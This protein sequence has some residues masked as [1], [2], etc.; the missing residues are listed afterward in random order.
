MLKTR[1]DIFYN[2]NIANL[3]IL[4]D[5]F[6]NLK[7]RKKFYNRFIRNLKFYISKIDKIWDLTKR[8][9]LYMV[10]HI[11]DNKKSTE[12]TKEHIY[13]LKD[14]FDYIQNEKNFTDYSLYKLDKKIY[15]DPNC[16]FI[17]KNRYEE[18]QQSLYI[19]RQDLKCLKCE[20]KGAIQ[21]YG[22]WSNRTDNM[23]H[24]I[25]FGGTIPY[26]CTNCGN[27]G[28]DYYPLEGYE[29]TFEKISINND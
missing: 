27:R 19:V 4:D 15:D 22:K 11:S 7:E 2:K 18:S 20:H 9:A 29:V 13:F 26:E 14:C 1:H 28:L 16:L 12:L 24:A 25:G 17:K 3:D 5:N 8:K 21:A 6:D 10:L 23:S